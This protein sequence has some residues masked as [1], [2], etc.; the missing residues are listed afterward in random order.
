MRTLSFTGSR[1]VG[2]KLVEQAAHQLLRVSVELGGNAPFIAF[3][4]ADLEQAVDEAMKAK[5]RNN[6]EART[7]GNRSL[8]K[9]RPGPS[10]TGSRNAFALWSPGAA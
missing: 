3:E 6:C 7:V 8:T 5:L 1:P 10:R 9:P 2:K 4:D